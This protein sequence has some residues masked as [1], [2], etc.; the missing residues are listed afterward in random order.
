MADAQHDFG[1]I[2]EMKPEAIGIPGNRRF[3][4]VFRTGPRT[5]CFW[6]E[7]EQLGALADAINE[8]MGQTEGGQGKTNSLPTGLYPEPFEVEVQ[9]GRLALGFN[10]LA[11]LFIIL[12]Y[13]IEIERAIVESAETQEEA[14]EKIKGMAP[15]IRVEA[16]RTQLERFYREAAQVINSGRVRPSKNGHIPYQQQ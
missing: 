5:A 3:R 1:P 7:K 15:I 13:D 4:V 11:D 2:D 12:L 14:D 8:L 6:M 16:S 9:T 10:D